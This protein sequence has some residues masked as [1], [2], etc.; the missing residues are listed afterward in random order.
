M[1][2]TLDKAQFRAVNALRG[3]PEGA[4]MM[5]MTSRPIEAGGILE[6]AREDFDELVS[7]I[8]EELADAMVSAASGR[9]LASVAIAIDPDSVDWLGM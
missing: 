4:H 8:S 6:G 2:V 7:H 3:L 1:K 5:V 9:A